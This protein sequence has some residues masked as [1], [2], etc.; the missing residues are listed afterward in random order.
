MARNWLVLLSLACFGTAQ[1]C[2]PLA[3]EALEAGVWFVPGENAVPLKANC[4][5]VAN[6]VVLAGPAGLVVVDP[7]PTRKDGLRLRELIR[8]QIGRPVVAVVASHAHPENVL[9]ASVFLAPGV[10]FVSSDI[11][12]ARM[13]R[14]CPQCRRSLGAAVGRAE[15]S[16]TRIVLPDQTLDAARD[17]VDLAGSAWRVLRFEDGHLPGNMALYDSARGLLVAGGLVNHARVPEMRDADLNAWMAALD[18][19]AQLAPRRVLPGHGAPG[20]AT[21]I[22][23]LRGYLERLER[24]VRDDVEAGND[25]ASAPGRLDL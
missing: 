12:A 9:A 14:Y 17:R 6:S 22:A 4:G 23:A 10:R 5:R 3:L 21:M 16:G 20:D 19:L 13:R 7:G 11:T 15:I 1:A 8:R 2:P 18:E 25:A 24:A